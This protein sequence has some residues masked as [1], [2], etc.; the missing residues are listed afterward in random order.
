MRIGLLPIMISLCVMAGGPAHSGPSMDLPEISLG[1]SPYRSFSD[2]VVY[3]T[4]EDVLTV[5]EGQEFIVTMFKG[6]TS[7]FELLQGSTVILRGRAVDQKSSY[8]IA[9]GRGHLRIEEGATLSVRFISTGSGHYYLQGYF[10]HAG[11]PY[12][13]TNGTSSAT[14]PA[15]VFTADEDRDFLARTIALNTYSCDVYVDGSMAL[16]GQSYATFDLGPH[17][18][19][20]MSGGGFS[21][22]LGG[23]VLPAG[24]QLQIGA[25]DG[26]TCDYYIDG[27]YLSP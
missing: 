25:R 24:S 11:S 4:T 22:G 16:P 15:T 9:L 10:V 7:S 6:Q 26:V 1:S 3:G 2:N 8:S 27:E 21:E 18:G 14:S 20:S 17:Y 12:R 19:S 23:L 5:P 13:A